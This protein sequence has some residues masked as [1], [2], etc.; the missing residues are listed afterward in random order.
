MNILTYTRVSRY[1]LPVLFYP[2]QFMLYLFGLVPKP[3]RHCT[4]FLLGT[5]LFFWSGTLFLEACYGE[6]YTLVPGSVHVHSTISNGEKTPEEI[7]TLAQESGI[8]AVIFTDHDTMRWAYGLSPLRRIIQKVT[9]QNSILK[10]GAGNYIDT[11]EELDKKYPN[12]LVIHG[13][14]SIPFYY[15]Q[16]SVFEKNLTLLNGN[17]HILTVGLKTTSDYQGLPSVGNGFP[18]HFNGESALSL[19]P[20]SLF[21]LG[22]WFMTQRVKRSKKE[23]VVVKGVRYHRTWGIISLFIGAVFLINN[24]PFTV[25]LY[26]QYHG[27]QG[28]GPYQ[29]LIDYVKKR[30][31]LTFWAHPEAERVTEMQGVKVASYPYENDLLNTYNYTGIAVFSEGMRRIG[32]PGGIWDQILLQYCSG[33]RERPAWILG[34]VDYKVSDF[35]LDETQTVFCVQK[36]SKEELLHA[37]KSGKMYAV[38][39]PANALTLNNFVVEEEQSGKFASMGEEIQITETPR[40]KFSITVNHDY[41]LSEYKEKGFHIDLIRNGSVIKTFEASDSVD[42]VYDDDFNNPNEKIYYRLAIDTSYL[43]RGIVSNPI[44]VTFKKTLNP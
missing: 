16:G 40:I 1:C 41:Q 14:E 34:E 33:E 25:Q 21:V 42:I 39:G 12:T 18:S 38:M 22:W 35:P 15:W 10:F 36:K 37:M 6:E 28:V 29:H 26:D 3:F 32:P 43:F 9:N 7:V 20:L 11:I 8:E 24:F 5:Y 27:D 19:W 17:K 30:G 4:P 31:G 23:E 2:T 44:F 13:T